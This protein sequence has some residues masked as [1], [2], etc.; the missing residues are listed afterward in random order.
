MHGDLNKKRGHKKTGT[1]FGVPHVLVLNC[2]QKRGG[3]PPLEGAGGGV[4][5]LLVA[6]LLVAGLD[7]VAPAPAG[8]DGIPFGCDPAG[9]VPVGCEPAGMVAVPV[10]EPEPWAPALP[11]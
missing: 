6:G 10:E 2:D 11:G 1:L 9:A 7:C 4:L 8:V 3:T 5:G